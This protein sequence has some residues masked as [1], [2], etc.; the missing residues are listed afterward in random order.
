MEQELVDRAEARQG[1]GA[2]RL[3]RDILEQ[4]LAAHP[5]LDEDQEAMVR[6]IA[7][8]GA[9]VDVVVGKAGTGKTHAMKVTREAFEAAGILV[10]GVTPTGQ[11]AAVLRKD[12]GI[13]ATTLDRLLVDVAN[14]TR[15]IPRGALVVLDEAGM[16][17]TRNRL[18]LQR[19]VDDA[20]AKVAQVGDHRQIPSVDVGGSHARLA[21]TLGAITLGKDHRLKHPGLRD[22]AEY[23]REGDAA[24]SVKLL[25]ELGMVHEHEDV[26]TIRQQMVGDW[27]DLL[28]Q[29]RDARMLA[30]ENAVVDELSLLAR[31]QLIERGTVDRKGRGYVS[32]D[33]TRKTTL[34]RGDR[35]RLGHNTTLTYPAAP[36]GSRSTTACTPPSSTPAAAAS[37]SASTPTTSPRTQTRSVTSPCRAGTPA[38]TSPTP[39]P[40]PPTKPK[41]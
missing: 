2:A 27:L 31:A 33:H 38:T 28:D 20:G 29:G 19:L 39:T 11:A 7:T 36:A 15:S 6:H 5:E 8:S 9:G 25:R 21:E 23:L 26:Q 37:T 10:L 12:G 24:Q 17:P 40:S 30:T 32:S 34:A 14:G 22:A 16:C 35:V 41:A 3:P 18:M 13:D 1:A 4:F